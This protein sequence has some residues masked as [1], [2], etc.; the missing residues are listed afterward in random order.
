MRRTVL[1]VFLVALVPCL[2]GCDL[3][4]KL[5]ARTHLRH[6]PPLSILSGL[7][8]LRYTENRDVSFNALRHVPE[9]VRHPLVLTVN[10]VA[11]GFLLVLL[12]RHR[13]ERVPQVALLLVL[14]GALGNL[15]ER[16]LRGHVIDF[17]HLHGWPVFNL[18][19]TYIVAG[20]LLFG[21]AHLVLAHREPPAII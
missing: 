12:R 9:R 8:D 4:T 1:A 18:A 15:L 16:A 11:V 3:G 10:V 13:R 5:L 6:G 21:I 14:G 19:D 2:V 17:I 20:A 7:L